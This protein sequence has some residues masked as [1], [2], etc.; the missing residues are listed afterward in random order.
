MR[1]I[2]TKFRHLIPGYMQR[3]GFKPGII[4]LA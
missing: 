3:H 4:G 2:T 1:W